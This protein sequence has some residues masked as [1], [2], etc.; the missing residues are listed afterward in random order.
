M[1]INRQEQGHLIAQTNGSIKRINENQYVVNSQSNGGTYRVHS[2]AL[3]WVCS[4]PDHT[5]RGVKCK[6][7]KKVLIAPIN[8]IA[9]RYCNSENI[10]K[11]ALRKNKQNTIRD[12]CVKTVV[13]GF[14]LTLGSTE[15]I[16]PYRLLPLLCNCI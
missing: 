8:S 7:R 15:C 13:S 10:S 11:K 1:G 4:C 5:Y 2:T 3:G 9:C 12:I 16:Q 14:H 6:H